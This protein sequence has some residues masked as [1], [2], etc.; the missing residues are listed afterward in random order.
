M[1]TIYTIALLSLLMISCGKKETTDKLDSSPAVTVKVAKVTPNNNHPFVTSSGKVTA[2]NSAELSTRMMGYVTNIYVKVGDNVTKGQLLLAINN[3]DLQ[4]KKAQVE[5]NIIKAKAGFSSAEKDYNRFKNLFKQNSAS[6]KEFDDISAHYNIAK[7]N[8]EAAKQLRNEI[9]SQFAYTNIRAPFSGVVTNKFIDKGA[10]ANP[11]MPLLSLEGKGGFE[12]TTLV[13]EN[14]IAQIKSNTKVDV[15]IKSINKTVTGTVSEVSTSAK[16]TGGQYQVKINLDKTDVPL[17]SG[18]FATVQFPVEK[19]PQSN[20]M[21]LVPTEALV[22]K[23][24]L[25]GIYTVSQS[26][27]ALLRWLRLGR[28][29]GSDVEILSGLNAGESYIISSEGKLYN[30]AKISVQ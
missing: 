9:N 6:Q 18:M 2:T 16:N 4:A 26:N 7:A 14:D 20:A 21:V 23:G 25:L 30:G 1:K 5:A 3:S 29:F 24:Q 12:V 27:T 8:L 22:H 11:G 15:L 13:A 17:L 28:T 19:T 10:M